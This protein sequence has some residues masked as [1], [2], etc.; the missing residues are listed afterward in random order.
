MKLRTGSNINLRHIRAFVAVAE[1]GSFTRAA[2]RLAVSQ[3][4]LTVSIQQLEAS[5]GLALFNRTTRRVTLTEAGTELLPTAERLLRD[6]QTAVADMQAIVDFRRG[7]V[8]VAA[9][10]SICAEW[11]PPIVGRFARDYPNIHVEVISGNSH[12]VYRR[13][14]NKEVDFGFAGQI[15]ANGEIWHQKVATQP[16]ELVCP[17]EHPLASLP[18]PVR[19]C[20]LK[21]STF[22]SAGNDDALNRVIADHPELSE[23][24]RD[25]R[26]RTNKAEIVAAM[27]KENIGVTAVS[28]M[29][30]PEGIRKH[31][32][33]RKLSEP[34]VTRKIYLI[35]RH[36][37][38]LS[39]TAQFFLGE[40]L[41]VVR[42]GTFAGQPEAAEHEV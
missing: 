33:T 10:P 19:W 31:L 20:D 4:A 27:V 40:S 9:L 16:V 35:R 13:V 36:G 34:E 23:T 17:P 11:L 38:T 37:R 3:S 41:K 29:I 26:Y 22:I 14:A 21:G 30:L 12:S 18:E 6:F 5:I 42:T 39:P 8:G 7:R 15:L 25:T 1:V 32:V 2:G 24:L 28:P